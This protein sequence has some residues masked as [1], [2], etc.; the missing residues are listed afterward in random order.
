MA[1]AIK[2]ILKHQP[3]G[4][5]IIDSGSDLQAF[6]EIEYLERSEKERVGLPYNWSEV[7]R[8]CSAIIDDIKF[9]RQFNLI[10]TARMKEEYVG[11]KASGRSVP[12]IYSTLPYKA[13]VCLEFTNDKERRLLVTKN[14]FTGDLSVSIQRSEPL[15]SILQRLASCSPCAADAAQKEKLRR[16]S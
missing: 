9:S 11:D 2:H 14:G 16:V 10:V 5:I 4:T 13:D 8:L 12:R 7:W 1:V 6:A 15:S 3:P